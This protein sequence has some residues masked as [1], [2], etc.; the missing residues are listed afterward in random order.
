MSGLVIRDR[1]RAGSKSDDV[2]YAPES[3]SNSERGCATG[4][5]GVMV[6]LRR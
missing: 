3:G 5:C 2:S 6:R 1:G 4:R